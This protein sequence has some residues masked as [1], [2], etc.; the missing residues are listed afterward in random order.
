MYRALYRKYRPLRFLDVV[1]QE[2]ITTALQNQIMADKIGHAYLFTGTRG[3]GKTTCAK[4]F[5]KAVNCE[6][7]QG[8]EPC[9][10]CEPCIGIDN[11]SILDVLEIDA[12][13]NNS[14]DDIRELREETAYR[15]GRCKYRVYIIDEVHMLSTSAFNALLKIMEEPPSHVLFILAT[16]EIHKVPATIQSRCQR[17]DFLRIPANKMAARLLDVAQKENISLSTEAADLIARLSDGALRDALSLLD[18]CSG[19]GETVNEP[20]VRRMAGVADR[21]HLFAISSVLSQG[22]PV[23][24]LQ[25]LE[26]QRERS[27]DA[28]RL[29]EELVYHY[30]NFVLAHA[31]SDGI[32]LENIPADERQTYMQEKQYVSEEQAINAVKVLTAAMDRMGRSPNPRIELEVALFDIAKPVVAVV[33]AVPVAASTGRAPS[34]QPV[35]ASLAPVA[36][37]AFVPPTPVS[38]PAQTATPIA[39]STME[40]LQSQ[41]FVPAVENRQQEPVQGMASMSTEDDEIMET[42]PPQDN[43]VQVRSSAD[44]AQLDDQVPFDVWPQVLEAVSSADSFLHSLMLGT[45]AYT[46][47]RRVFIQGKEMFMTYMRDYPDTAKK[48]REAIQQVTGVRYGIAPYKQPE[49]TPELKKNTAQDTVKQWESLGIPIEYE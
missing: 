8:A 4:I 37:K 16:T 12:A 39:T 20:L 48:I 1:G 21:E 40:E 27:V 45:H 29:C 33:A 5:A 26:E 41:E 25:L 35:V 42:L 28:R 49:S 3:T 13:S 6:N 22:K 31:A 23:E 2:A 44:N 43:T 10:Q 24:A 32:L 9:G 34:P 19:L 7:P 38:V 14:V 18:T 11:G 15:P 47:N 30:R 46:D 17:F 36:P